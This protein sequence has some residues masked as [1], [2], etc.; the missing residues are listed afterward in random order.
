[1]IQSF[2][3][4]TIVLT[5]RLAILACSMAAVW[6]CSR[7]PAIQYVEGIVTLDE[8]PVEGAIITFTPSGSGLGAAGT[9]D[10][11]GVYRLNPLTGR[12][13]GG[14]LAG[15]YLVAV[16]KWEYQDPGPAP[17]PSDQKAYATWQVKSLKAANHEPTYI[18]PK[19]YGDA[20]TSG[21]KATVK[22]GRNIGPAFNFALKSDYK[23]L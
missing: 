11:S 8:T 13:G 14:T 6:G 2:P 15:D 17:D 9:T 19:A 4:M 12:A 3:G 16:R 7:V 1:M 5:T 20:A 22:Q 18:T 23:G 10:S 21:L